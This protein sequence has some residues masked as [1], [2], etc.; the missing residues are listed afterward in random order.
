MFS[1]FIQVEVNIK[2]LAKLHRHYLDLAF[3][4][5]FVQALMLPTGQIHANSIYPNS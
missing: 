3:A 2:P 4:S 1:E 5:T